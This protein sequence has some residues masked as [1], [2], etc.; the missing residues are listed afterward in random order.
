MGTKERKK[1]KR[2]EGKINFKENEESRKGK[3]RKGGRP[4]NFKLNL[5][6]HFPWDYLPTIS[7]GLDVPRTSFFY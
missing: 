3:Q 7:M 2:K 5:K 6:L 1:G 4:C